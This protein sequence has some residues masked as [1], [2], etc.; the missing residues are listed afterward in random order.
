MFTKYSGGLQDIRNHSKATKWLEQILSIYTVDTSYGMRATAYLLDTDATKGWSKYYAGTDAEYAIGAPTIELFCA[1]YKDT[2][3]DR[4]IVC[5]GERYAI[6]AC[7]SIHW[8]DEDSENVDG[9]P[10]DE[11]NGIYIKSDVSKEDDTWIASPNNSTLDGA[12]TLIILSNDIDDGDLFIGDCE[13]GEAGIR[14][15]ICLKSDVQLE[16]VSDGTY[17]IVH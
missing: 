12:D 2:H 13:N 5:E 17:Q 15:I 16:K 11:Y 4:Y 10:L 9:L 8:N 7:Y 14:P 3:P 1:S 6:D